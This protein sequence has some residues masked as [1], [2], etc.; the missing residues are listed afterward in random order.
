MSGLDD[1]ERVRDANDIVE[2]VSQVVPLKQAGKNFRGLC[3]FHREKTPSFYVTPD[4]QTFKCFG[5]GVGGDVFEFVM[6]HDNLTFPEALREL[7]RRGHV[8][9]SDRP[10]QDHPEQDQ[11]RRELYAVMAW[12]HSRFQ[13]ALQ[14]ADVGQTARAYLRQRQVE[15]ELAESFGLGFAPSG[16]DNLLRAGARDHYSRDILEKAGLVISQTEPEKRYDR[17]RNRLMFP[18]WDLQGRPVG[19]GGRLLG[20]GE[21]KYLNSPE[22]PLFRKGELLYA[23]NLARDATRQ[24]GRLVLVEGYMD[25]MACHAAGIRETVATLGTALTPQQAK[26][27]KRYARQVIL[28]YDADEAGLNATQRAFELLNTA[29]VSVKVAELSGAKDPD[30]LLRAQGVKALQRS[31]AQA[32]SV[33]EFM[34]SAAIRRGNSGTIEGKLKVVREVGPLILQFPPDGI[35]QGEYAHL[36]AERLQLLDR[37]VVTELNRL[38]GPGTGSRPTRDQAAEAAREPVEAR[39]ALE[40]ELIVATLLRFPLKIENLRAS[41]D[42]DLFL[43]TEYRALLDKLLGVPA[44]DPDQEEAWFPE[45]RRTL[46]P[47]LADLASRLAALDRGT[48]D[49]DRVIR[50]CL[51]RLEVFRLQDRLAGIRIRIQEVEK[52]DLETLKQLQQERFELDK[53]LNSFGVVWKS[54]RLA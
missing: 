23:L 26:I 42:L 25:V 2:V 47:E 51:N 48:E 49:P 19:F 8:T 29:G 6:R 32:V 11:A 35:E 12:A 14:S 33:V 50:D 1:K 3:P 21:P 9:L 37:Q 17:F 5:C 44:A 18:I 24:A 43:V 10:G 7:A 45:F 39:K 46:G 27:M 22:T 36:V 31:L 52:G 13:H 34:L 38:R 41:L 15:D 40:E 53:R 30:D 54:D 4:R 28:L 16:W 20:P